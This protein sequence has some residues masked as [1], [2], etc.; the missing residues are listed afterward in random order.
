MNW[1]VLIR[2]FGPILGAVILALIIYKF[3]YDQA[4]NE[5]FRERVE[6][7]DI[8]RQEMQDTERRLNDEYRTIDR[9]VPDGDDIL[10]SLRETGASTQTTEPVDTTVGP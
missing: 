7:E 5:A 6:A 4:T 10:D 8:A 2:R 1:L 3:G 9:A